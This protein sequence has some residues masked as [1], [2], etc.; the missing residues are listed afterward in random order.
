MTAHTPGPW[1]LVAEKGFARPSWV[2]EARPPAEQSIALIMS[3]E[4]NARL[5]AS[6]PELL[7]SLRKTL[8]AANELHGQGIGCPDCPAD[9]EDT[10]EDCPML[11]AADA[12]I[13]KA[14]SRS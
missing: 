13:A 7:A 11:L 2:I 8:A 5:I 12:A 3:T 9:H 10:G 1:D 4:A 14:E 6:A